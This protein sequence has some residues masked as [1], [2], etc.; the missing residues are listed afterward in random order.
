DVW[1]AI[2]DQIGLAK[3]PELRKQLIKVRAWFQTQIAAAA[4]REIETAYRESADKGWQIWLGWLAEAVTRFR[5]IFA[6]GLFQISVPFAEASRETVAELRTSVR[7]MSHT[8]WPEAYDKLSYLGDQQW[9]PPKVRGRIQ[10][11]LGQIQ[12][13]HFSEPRA[14]RQFLDTAEKLAP[15]DGK[16]LSAVGQYWV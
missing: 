11:M 15:E 14:A 12:L 7:L 10:S 5:F 16:I 1:A 4:V 3:T 6:D 8:R 2:D 13:F 9:L